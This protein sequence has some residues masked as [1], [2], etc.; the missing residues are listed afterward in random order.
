MILLTFLY[1]EYIDRTK[2]SEQK[3]PFEF[4]VPPHT[5]GIGTINNHSLCVNFLNVLFLIDT[6]KDYKK[7]LFQNTYFG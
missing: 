6:N 2:L 7:K 1:G 3:K 4:I 5:S